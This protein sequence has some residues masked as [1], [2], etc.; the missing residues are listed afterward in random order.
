MTV[1]PPRP[2]VAECR[3][4]YGPLFER[5]VAILYEADPLGLCGSGAPRD[6]YALELTTILPRFATAHSLADAQRIVHEEFV[7]WFDL[8]TAGDPGRYRSVGSDLWRL[9]QAWSTL[10][11]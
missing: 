8:R 4:W 11:R 3:A 6:E 2:S 1:D 5:A 9:Y 7:R 10:D